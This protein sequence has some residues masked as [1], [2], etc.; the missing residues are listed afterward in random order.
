MKALCERIKAMMF[1]KAL[2]IAGKAAGQAFEEIGDI[3]QLA[4]VWRRVIF[5]KFITVLHS[6]TTASEEQ[7]ILKD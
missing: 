2:G 4:S 7:E 1:D 5:N 6:N 3:L